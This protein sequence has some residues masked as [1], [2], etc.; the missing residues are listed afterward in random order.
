MPYARNRV[1]VTVDEMV[2]YIR[3]L[4][5][6]QDSSESHVGGTS[7]FYFLPNNYTHTYILL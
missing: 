4:H 3:R 2:E 1:F 5:P 7:N 6:N